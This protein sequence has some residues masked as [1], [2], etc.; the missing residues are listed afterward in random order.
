MKNIIPSDEIQFHLAEKAIISRCQRQGASDKGAGKKNRICR[1][2]SGS[3]WFIVTG[4]E[5]HC[6]LTPMA[7]KIRI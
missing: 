6:S 4:T 1:L 2:P 3:G 7:G 5:K